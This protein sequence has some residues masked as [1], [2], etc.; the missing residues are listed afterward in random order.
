MKTN[1]FFKFFISL[2]LV[3]GT[4]NSCV[5]DNSDFA[6]PQ[7]ICQ[8]PN[9]TVTNTL[10]E[11][12][13][14]A[15]GAIHQITDDMVVEGYVVSSDE[16]GNFFSSVSIQN[17]EGTAG[18]RLSIDRRDIY[19]QIKVGQKVYVKAKTLFI[20]GDGGDSDIALGALFG[21]FIGR[22]PDVEIDNFLFRSCESVAESSLVHTATLDAINNGLLNTLVEFDNVQFKANEVGGNYFDPNNTAGSATNRHIVDVNGN[23]L[24]VRNSEFADFANKALPSGNGKIRGVLSKF[25][26]DYQLFIRDTND[27]QFTN[28]RQLWGFASDVTGNLTTIASLRDAFNSGTFSITDNAIIEGVITMSTQNGNLTSRNAFIQDDS[29]AIVIRFDSD[30]HSLFEGYKVRVNVKDLSLGTFAGLLQISNVTQSTS[31]QVLEINASMP[32]ALTVSIDD[33]LSDAYQ[34]QLVQLDNVQFTQTLVGFG[35]GRT[36]TD[37]TSSLPV[38]TSSFAGFANNTVPSGNGSITGIAS[39]FNGAQLLIRNTN[40]TSGLTGVRCAQAEPFFSQDFESEPNGPDV[41][42]A[43][44]LN[45]A[46][47]GSVKWHSEAFGGNTYTEFSPYRS[48]DA[49]NIGWMITPPIDMDTHTSEVLTFETAQHH[50]DQATLEV[51]ISNDFDGTEAGIATA[52]WVDAGATIATGTDSWYNFI[53]SG[54]IDLSGYTGNIY[55]AFKFTGNDSNASGGFFVDNIMVLGK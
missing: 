22:L 38:F 52:T 17:L 21:S 3:L 19:T 2:V 16:Q 8:E 28:P 34:G 44:W 32:T 55:V 14:N 13:V 25:N 53:P 24:I 41:N 1:A 46:E 10:A 35:G 5:N 9:L 11:L 15:V 6:T 20:D 42:I 47:T 36:L 39:N 18:F 50:F 23:E 48:G 43:G 4:F 12:N 51:F 49:S 26:G 37:C 30:A 54:N 31:V 7:V 40:D 33:V 29:G 45:V 27:V